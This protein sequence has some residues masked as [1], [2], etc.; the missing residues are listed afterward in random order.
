MCPRFRER[1]D[2][3]LRG[4]VF[5]TAEATAR[6][7]ERL[8]SGV[9]ATTRQEHADQR[10]PVLGTCTQAG[11]LH[12]ATRTLAGAMVMK[13][14]LTSAAIAATI[15]VFS[16]V[17]TAQQPAEQDPGKDSQETTKKTTKKGETPKD[18]KSGQKGKEG[19]VSEKVKEGVREEETSAKKMQ[20]EIVGKEQQQENERRAREARDA[21]EREERD[22][23]EAQ[24]A[25]EAVGR[26]TTT[27]AT[28]V[29]EAGQDVT[30]ALDR[31]GKYNPVAATW[32]PLGAIVGGRISF[33]VEYAPVTHHVI[34]ASPHFAN[35]S[36]EVSVGP[37]VQR[38]NRFTGVGGELGYRYYT[39]T[40]G[41]NGIFIGPSIIGG[42]YNASL[43]QGDTAFT[44]IGVAADIGVQQIFWD[45]LA[46]GAGAGIEYL[47]V[48]K[49][50]GDLSAGAS[51]IASSGLKPRLLA[52]AGYAF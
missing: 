19:S 27:A 3:A 14:K 8:G 30:R 15:F 13:S 34:I 28:T 18:T 5:D 10:E 1:R 33:N 40:R 48:S 2:R 17:A 25:G 7:R 11:A 9:R 29:I 51:T 43:I 37:D 52:Q 50:F 35:P 26:A 20:E 46:L 45:H 36:Q 16:S 49:E 6:G 42:V 44:N 12:M 21:R 38:T 32:N 31:P 22:R 47:S 23:R 41:M 4:Y 24:E 39:G